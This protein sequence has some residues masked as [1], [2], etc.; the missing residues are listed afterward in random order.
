MVKLNWGDP[1]NRWFESGVSQVV[2][3]VPQEPGVHWSGI[4]EINTKTDGGDIES[5]HQDGLKYLQ[6][7]TPEDFIIDISAISTP[8][9][10]NRCDGIKEIALGLYATQQDRLPF[11]LTY[12][13][14]IQNSDGT[15]SNEFKIHVVYNALSAP[16]DQTHNT[17]T[18]DPDIEPRTWSCGT[19]GEPLPESRPVAHIEIDS[20]KVDDGVMDAVLSYLHGDENIEPRILYPDQ[21]MTLAEGETLE[22]EEEDDE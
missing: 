22:W 6:V 1:N 17:I 21:L 4:T 9:E 20:R 18:D 12:R 19:I 7:S 2:I 15:S 13:T 11:H 8:E 16:A 5:F 14:E 3:Y 10:F